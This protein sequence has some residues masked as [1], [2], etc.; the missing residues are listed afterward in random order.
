[1]QKTTRMASIFVHYWAGAKAAAGEATEHYEG[2]TVAEA[3]A[4]A[5]ARH[6]SERFARVLR[7]STVLVDGLAAHPG[8]LERPVTGEVRVEILPPFAGGAG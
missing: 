6:P 5:R 3:L 4:T 2:A 8:D 7:V 1:M